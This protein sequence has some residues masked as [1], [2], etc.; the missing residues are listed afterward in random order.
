[1]NY[2]N[3]DAFQTVLTEAEYQNNHAAV[4]AVLNVLLK[5]VIEDLTEVTKQIE[6]GSI[7]KHNDHYFA[8]FKTRCV[9]NE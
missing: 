1:M 7:E 9:N 5:A 2:D 6:N 8:K 3:L 4:R